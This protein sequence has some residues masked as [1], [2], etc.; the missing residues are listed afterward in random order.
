[1][2]EIPKVITLELFRAGAFHEGAILRVGKLGVNKARV[3]VVWFAVVGVNMRKCHLQV[4]L[5][6]YVFHL[7]VV[8]PLPATPH[9]SYVTPHNNHV[10]YNGVTS[11]LCP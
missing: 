9:N 11:C 10:S 2:S 4:R 6:S 1:M 8:G 5:N 3:R 7:H